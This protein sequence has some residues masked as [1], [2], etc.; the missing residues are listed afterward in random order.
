MAS[1]PSTQARGGVLMPSSFLEILGAAGIHPTL[2]NGRVWV[3]SEELT[4]KARGFLRLWRRAI[5]AELEARDRSDTREHDARSALPI[6]ARPVEADGSLDEADGAWWEPWTVDRC[7]EW[8]EA[9]RRG[10]C[11]VSLSASGVE[12]R[13]AYR[14]APPWLL[15]DV[16]QLSR[17]AREDPSIRAVLEAC[18]EPTSAPSESAAAHVEPGADSP[19]VRGR[20]EAVALARSAVVDATSAPMRRA[21]RTP[22]A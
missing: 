22:S 20:V 10:G 4:A 7:R 15:S 19:A 16:W 17:A 13:P 14:Y 2:R 12:L 11:T 1:D 6:A 21:R 18:L 9:A 5:V 8:L 3:R